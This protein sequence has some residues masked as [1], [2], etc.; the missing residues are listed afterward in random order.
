LQKNLK[1]QNYMVGLSRSENLKL[2]ISDRAAERHQ[3]YEPQ[4]P[5]SG[6]IKISARSAEKIFYVSLHFLLLSR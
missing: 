3:Q 6:G 5:E 1:K 2:T 4:A